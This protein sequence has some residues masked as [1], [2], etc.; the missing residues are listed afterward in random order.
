M[1]KAG[2]VALMGEMKKGYKM[3]VAKSEGK[4]PVGRH[5]RRWEDNIRVDLREMR[6]KVVDWIHVA[7][8]R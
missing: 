5:T 1:R 3:F 6:W 7:W 4:R 8:D 2:H